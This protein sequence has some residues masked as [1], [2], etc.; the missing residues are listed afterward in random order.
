MNKFIKI[1]KLL[2]R[3]PIWASSIEYIPR[4]KS[5]DG[6]RSSY[7]DGK[8]I[9]LMG[10]VRKISKNLIDNVN[11]MPTDLEICIDSETLQTKPSKSDQILIDKQRYKIIDIYELG[12][13]DNKPSA[14][15]IILRLA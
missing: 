10:V 13:I 1:T 7:S 8:S 5:V 6:V 15:Q 12:I 2:L 11:I 4:I 14:F 9:T 3:N